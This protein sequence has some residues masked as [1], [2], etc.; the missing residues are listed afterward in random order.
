MDLFLREATERIGADDALA[1]IDALVDWTSFSPILKRGLGRSG[2][3][4]QGYDP[5]VLFKC[6]KI[7]PRAKHRMI[8][9][10]ISA[11]IQMPVG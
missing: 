8:R 2:V 6:Q 10:C 7:G 9:R 11:P 4:P 1:K 3:G 5:V